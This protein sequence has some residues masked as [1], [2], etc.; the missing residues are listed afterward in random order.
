MKYLLVGPLVPPVHGQSLAFT[1]FYESIAEKNKI[2]INTNLEDKSKIGKFAH[3][4]R[5]LALIIYKTL[6]YQF[7]TV[8]FTC[9][10]SFLGSIKD[11]FLI[12]LANFRNK[13]IINHLHGS[14]FYDFIHN[15]PNWY[16]KILIHSYSKVHTSIV[17]L[18]TMKEQ[19]RDFPHMELHVVSNFYD[20]DLEK[21]LA[22][23]DSEKINLLYLSNIMKSKG[24]LELIDAFEQLSLKHKH[25]NL[26]IAGGFIADEFMSIDEIKKV[27]LEK[28][29][30]I[31]TLKYV[32]KIF[33]E[34][35]VTL[36]QKSDIFVLPSYYK[37][38]AFPISIIEAMKSSNAIITTNYKFL[39]EIIKDQNGFLVEIK[40]VD[41]LQNALDKLVNDTY[42]LRS[43]Q[44]HNTQE[45]TQKY[46]LKNYINQLHHIV[47]EIV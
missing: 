36:L 32:G 6:F 41:S 1:R 9:S 42:L 33:G 17:L 35:K 40:S 30:T 21:T 5:T 22:T 12:N 20:Q 28:I 11:I 7:D 43:I 26:T 18:E 29:Q 14:D 31:P 4:F 34:E 15:S 25:L 19:F 3:T 16:Q 37:S 13:R 46:S 24:V 23:K 8:Y 10:R 27:F 47:E 45:A 44:L 38:E 39:P 2:I